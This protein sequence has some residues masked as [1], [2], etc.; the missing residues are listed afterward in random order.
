MLLQLL[1]LISKNFKKNREPDASKS[2]KR[3]NNFLIDAAFFTSNFF[4]IILTLYSMND[5]I[6]DNS[7]TSELSTK[8]SKLILN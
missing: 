8:N 5:L 3:K 4:P 2:L 1:K 6:R 7:L